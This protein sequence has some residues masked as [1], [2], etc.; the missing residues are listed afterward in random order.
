MGN[1]CDMGP[2][3]V[4]SNGIVWTLNTT[5]GST[6]SFV[7][8]NSDCQKLDLTEDDRAMLRAMRIQVED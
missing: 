5:T 7:T 8:V 4:D 1:S 3:F 6:D 2:V